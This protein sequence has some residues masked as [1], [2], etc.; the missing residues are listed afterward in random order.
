MGVEDFGFYL[1]HVPGAFYS[2]GV[3]NEA[4]GIVHPVHHELLRRRRGVHGLRRRAAGAE[5]AGD[6]ATALGSACGRRPARPSLS[7]AEPDLGRVLLRRASLAAAVAV[8]R[9]A[10]TTAVW[11]AMVAA[12]FDMAKTGF[13]IALGLTGMMCL[14]LGIMKLGEQGGAIEFLAAAVRPAAPP[15]VPRRAGGPSGDG[16]DGDEHRRQ[17][18]R[19]RQRRHAARPQGD[20]GAAD[21][22]PGAGT[23]HQR[24]GAVPGDQHRV[25]D[26]DPDLDLRLP[27]AD[28]R[29]RSRPTSSFR[30]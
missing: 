7:N 29:R 27:R 23:R 18:A 15:A 2:L 11:A 22:Q 21:P 25:G 19:A 6:A 3:R 30:C 8:A 12:A 4:R 10:A 14:W 26:A 9:S 24:A 16:R 28:G 20:E 13:E 17:H 1:T 5:R